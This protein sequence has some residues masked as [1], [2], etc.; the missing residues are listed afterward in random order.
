M[1][2]L[3]Y[4]GKVPLARNRIKH[5]REDKDWKPCSVPKQTNSLPQFSVLLYI[6]LKKYQWQRLRVDNKGVHQITN[7]LLRSNWSLD[8]FITHIICQ[9]FLKQVRND[10]NAIRKRLFCKFWDY[11]MKNPSSITLRLQVR[12][13]LWSAP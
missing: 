6:V 1:M 4:Y 2:L 7:P 3:T 11:R 9:I 12:R 10:N 5:Y 13:V 8:C